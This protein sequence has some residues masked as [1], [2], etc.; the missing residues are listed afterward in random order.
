M[1]KCNTSFEYYLA[2]FSFNKIKLELDNSVLE[3]S[4]SIRS[5]INDSQ[6]KL[7][8]IPAAFV[9]GVSQI[10]FANPFLLKNF[11]IVASSFFIF[12]HTLHFHKK[13]KKN[14]IEIISDN[15]SNYKN[16]L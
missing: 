13:I 8:A 14:A 11:L 2:N 10:D 5:I 6:T 1:K 4:K 16:K 9:L 15:L 12:L 7:V 3:Y